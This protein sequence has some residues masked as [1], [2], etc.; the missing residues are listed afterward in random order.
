[1]VAK[2]WHKAWAMGADAEEC[3]AGWTHAALHG[4]GGGSCGGGA[5][6][7][8][9]GGEQGGEEQGEGEEGRG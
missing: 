2:T 9:G 6:A 5:G 3:A 8:A 7:D 4:C 1:M